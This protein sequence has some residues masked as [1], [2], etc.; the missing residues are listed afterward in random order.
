MA[1]RGVRAPVKSSMLAAMQVITLMLVAVAMATA[2]AHALEFPG[3]LRLS[4]AE[5]K[6]VQPIYYP[7]FTFAGLFGE[8]GG[9]LATALLLMVTPDAMPFWLVLA[10]LAALLLMHALYWLL[11]HPVNNFWLER[12]KLGA[13]GAAFFATGAGDTPSDWRSARNRW[14]VSHVARAVCALAGLALIA[15]AT[16]VS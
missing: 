15:T 6:T 12:E 7:G 10:A 9:I 11:T 13:A 3:K 8:F 4:E 2:L 5:Y 14:E 1:E 16:A